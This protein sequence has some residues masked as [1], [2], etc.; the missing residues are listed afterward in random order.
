MTHRAIFRDSTTAAI[1]TCLIILI[2][3]STARTDE[4]IRVASIY[5]FS[6][7]AALSQELSIKGVRSGISEVNSRGGVLGKKLMLIEL[8]NKSSPIGTKVAA[9]RAVKEN[10]VAIIGSAWSSHTLPAAKVAQAAGIPL[11][12]NIS[13][14]PGIT[15]IGD[16]IFRVCFTDLFQGRVMAQFARLD[17]K[18]ATAVVF[19]NLNSDYSMS[20]SGEFCGNFEKLGG[21]ILLRSTYKDRQEDYSQIIEQAL[22]VHPDVLFI[23]GYDES[24]AIINKAHAAGLTAIFLG[25]DGWDMPD[26]F[27]KSAGKAT[28]GYYCTHWSKDMDSESSQNFV[29]KYY[30]YSQN[31]IGTAP[32]ALAYDA[33]LLLADAIQRAGSADRSAIRQA[34]ATAHDFK[35]VTG[36]IS[37]RG[38]GDPNKS[39]VIMKI[40]PN[41]AV[42]V[43]SISPE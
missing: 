40:V 11:I 24:G 21:K 28:G 31:D 6:G 22:Q 27:I 3:V 8:D 15:E 17:L 32:A 30:P 39:A 42:M 12:T 34:L 20:L 1:M 25:G 19:E 5:A 16:C 35:G 9:D 38:N 36:T 41:S 2:W 7:M 37:F 29:N 4:V 18:A 26:F 23:P 13:T 43:K 33:V 10:V 14:L